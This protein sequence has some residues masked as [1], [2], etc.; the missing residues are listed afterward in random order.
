MPATMDKPSI[1]NKYRPDSASFEEVYRDIHRNLELS[2]QEVRTANIA[3]SHLEGLDDFEVQR[4]VGGHDV[5]GVLRNGPGSTILLRADTD[6]LPHL[7]NTKLEYASTKVA[8]DH[9]GNETPVMHAGGHDMHTASL[10]AAATF[11]HAARTT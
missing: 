5:V 6:A 1:I 8:K 4:G 7:E 2:R 9:Q 3:A 10:M 11:L